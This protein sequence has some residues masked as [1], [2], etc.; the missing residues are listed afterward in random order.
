MNIPDA[1][2]IAYHLYYHEHLDRVVL[3][4]VHPLVANLLEAGRIDRFFFVRYRLGGPHIRLRLRPVSGQEDQVDLDVRHEAGQFLT[5][6][7]SKK[8]LDREIVQKTTESILARDSSETDD[9]IYP[10]NTL[11]V[12]SFTPEVERYGGPGLIGYSLDFFMASS[13]EVLLFMARNQDQPRT[14][15]LGGTLRLLLRQ[16]LGFAADENELAALLGY[17]EERGAASNP[18]ILSRGDQVFEKRK[19]MFQD[20]F[21]E[22]VLLMETD[23]SDGSMPTLGTAARALSHAMG[24]EQGLRLQV[25]TSQLHMTA[26]RLGLSNPEEVY[27]GRL[28]TRTCREIARA[29]PD[30]WKQ[31]RETLLQHAGQPQTV[32]VFDPALLQRALRQ[33]TAPGQEG[34][35]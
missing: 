32:P 26:N 1:Q 11:H 25:G 2:W 3:G 29:G 35:S 12:A 8:L 34:H 20:L 6:T 31:L 4:F 5:T 17:A 22:E 9:T 30:L 21:R 15:C 16:A 7:P 27:L 10:D 13:V 18:T 28:L 23:F 33:S 24:T 14:L 19:E